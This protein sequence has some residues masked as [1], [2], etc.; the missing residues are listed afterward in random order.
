MTRTSGLNACHNRAPFR[1]SQAVQDGWFMDG[2]S[3]TP[4]MVS[5]PFRMSPD[6][7]YSKSDLV[8]A[9]KGCTG[10]KWRQN[11]EETRAP[12]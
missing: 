9:D 3:R 4:R 1:T 12:S 7:E 8:Q 5:I 11:P 6:C 2:V 10:C